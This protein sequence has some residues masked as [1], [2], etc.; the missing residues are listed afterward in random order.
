[1]RERGRERQ[2][3]RQ[4]NGGG[5]GGAEKERKGRDRQTDRDTDRDRQ[6]D[7]NGRSV[8]P[9][10]LCC[11]STRLHNTPKNGA[12]VLTET[13]SGG[14]SRYV[15]YGI[16]H[17]E[18]ASPSPQAGYYAYR[19]G[20]ASNLGDETLIRPVNDSRETGP[21]THFTCADH[22]VLSCNQAF[23]RL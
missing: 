18:F 12:I 1:M 10:R 8:S 11:Q 4:R 22:A 21:S 2:R 7:R 23:H 3:Q 13:D 14:K 5:G 16:L 20:P 17:S 15:G 19:G 9:T 6:A